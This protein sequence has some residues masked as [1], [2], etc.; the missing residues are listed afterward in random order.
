MQVKKRG[1]ESVIGWMLLGLAILV[2][3]VITLGIF[4][5]K[6]SQYIEIIK[7]IFKFG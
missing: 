6:G 3:T 1:M 7:R 2:I 4:S 5:D